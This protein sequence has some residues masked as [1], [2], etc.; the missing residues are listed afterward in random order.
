VPGASPTA[1]PRVSTSPVPA[2]TPSSGASV[3]DLARQADAAY[4]RAQ[5]AL[6]NGDFATYGQEI[7]TVESLIQ[8]IVQ[9][10]GG[11]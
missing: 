3:N 11:Q 10:S 2:T 4:Q 6:R 9:R 7:A 1:T 5:A 8:Q